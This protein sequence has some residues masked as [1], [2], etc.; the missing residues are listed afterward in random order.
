M[1]LEIGFIHKLTLYL[2]NPLYASTTVIAVMLISS[3][4]GSLCFHLCK[5]AKAGFKSVPLIIAVLTGI[6]TFFLESFLN[7]AIILPSAVHIGLTLFLVAVPAF[8]MGI[9]F[10]YG[11]DKLS[12]SD[13]SQIPWAWGINSCFS[14]ISAVA[15]AVISVE[16][17]FKRLFLLV[18]VIYTIPYLINLVKK[19]SPE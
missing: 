5:S 19:A 16:F 6:Y 1:I 3:G 2:G 7:S 13:R 14:V 15:A 4:L 8:F 17:G 11:I 9:P 10:P 18:A 12:K